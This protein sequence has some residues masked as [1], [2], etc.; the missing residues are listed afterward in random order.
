MIEA[1][2]GLADDLLHQCVQLKILASSREGLG[3]AGEVTYRIP[4]LV[5]AESTQLFVER[6]RAANPKFIL[7]D[8]N[9]PAIAKICARLDGIPLAIELA[10]ARTKL[11]TPE[12]IAVRLD[13]RFRLLVGG[14]RTAL[15][16]QQTLR[17][18]IDWSYDLLSEEEKATPALRI[19]VRGWMD[20]GCP[21]S[22]IWRP[23]C[24]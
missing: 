24:H 7:T 6:A 5:E 1:C 22:C 4:S 16:R 13:D 23:K 9:R 11:L 17:A 2:A 3:I 20:I 14:S 15:P 8:I 21:R 18:L 19:R 12:Q 10:A